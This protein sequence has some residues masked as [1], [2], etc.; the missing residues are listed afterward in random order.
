MNTGLTKAQEVLAGRFLETLTKN[1]NGMR[2]SEFKQI[3][4]GSA[5]DD[6]VNHGS[7]Y[8]LLDQDP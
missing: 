1:P 2:Q 5:E 4:V 6:E 3:G 7:C 8:Q